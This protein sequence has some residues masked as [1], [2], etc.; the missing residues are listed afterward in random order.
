MFALCDNRPNKSARNVRTKALALEFVMCEHSIMT[1]AE[2]RSHL[3]LTLD[4]FGALF[5]LSSKGYVSDIERRNRCPTKLALAIEA[6]SNGLVNA[7]ELSEDVAAVR[8][9]AA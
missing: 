9:A 7:A 3:G 4:A 5:G 6:H 2:Y 8:K 1:I